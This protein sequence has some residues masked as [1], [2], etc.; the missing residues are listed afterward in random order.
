MTDAFLLHNF[1]GQPK[2]T[3]PGLGD[4]GNN[5]D[6]TWRFEAGVM[7]GTGMMDAKIKI[8]MKTVR[9]DLNRV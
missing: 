4:G 9:D 7:G 5:D 8:L 2:P 6:G 3:I 1:T